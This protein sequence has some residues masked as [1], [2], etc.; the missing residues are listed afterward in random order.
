MRSRYGPEIKDNDFHPG[1]AGC[2]L[3]ARDKGKCMCN[4]NHGPYGNLL[5]RTP[6]PPPHPFVCSDMV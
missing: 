4:P 1:S 2:G 6:V 3:P 5:Q